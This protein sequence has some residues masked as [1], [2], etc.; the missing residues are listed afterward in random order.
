MSS[1]LNG[2][3]IKLGTIP[4]DRLNFNL[5]TN[6]V[7]Y[8]NA[9]QTPVTIGGIAGGTTF[10]PSV[11]LQDVIDDLLYPTINPTISLD[12]LSIYE[13]GASSDSSINLTGNIEANTDT[14]S[15]IIIKRGST[16]IQTY[17]NPVDPFVLNYIDPIAQA[18]DVT[19][20]IEV[21][22]ATTL[23]QSSIQAVFVAPSFYGVAAPS[24]DEATIK[25]LTKIVESKSTQTLSFSPTLQ[26]FYYAYPNSFG[27]LSKIT[28]QNG[29]VL[30]NSFNSYNRTFTLDSGVFVDY[31][32]YEF[33]ANTTQ[34]NFNLT[35]TF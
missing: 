10:S 16:T 19:Y 31:I 2:K 8:E 12:A 11:N 34:S 20:N 27:A 18:T 5:D 14:I 28:D 9:V 25:G 32:I 30:T 13:F 3:Q 35:F 22:G 1:Q 15:S 4:K 17:S 21:Q 6:N 23:F 29:F 24:A 26:R 33:N 7:T